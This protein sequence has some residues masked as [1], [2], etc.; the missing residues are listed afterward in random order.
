VSQNASTAAPG[1][2][3]QLDLREQPTLGSLG[4]GSP[5]G[6]SPLCPDRPTRCSRVQSHSE[7]RSSSCSP[8]PAAA[9]SS[10]VDGLSQAEIREAIGVVEA[11]PQF[12]PGAFFPL[13][14]LHEQPKADLLAWTPG[15]AFRREALVQ[16][17]ERAANRTSEVVVDLRQ[18]RVVSWTVK[19]NRQ[20][21]STSASGPTPPRPSARTRVGEPPSARATCSR[22]TSTSTSG[23]RGHPRYQAPRQ[24]RGCCA[25]S[26]STAAR[27]RIR[28]TVRSRAWSRRW[29]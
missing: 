12:M 23:R 29:T 13:V 21:V 17:Y 10:P 3:G 27:C 4:Y 19:P 11:A 14:T 22:G 15:S 28:M 16:V 2:H 26:P 20:Q 25:A 7:P 24:A 1:A 8:V 5:L 6:K 9:Q 18:N